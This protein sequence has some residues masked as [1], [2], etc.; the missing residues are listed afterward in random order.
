MSFNLHV[1]LQPND[2]TI[3]LLKIAKAQSE[4]SRKNRESSYCIIR[5]FIQTFGYL[6]F[7]SGF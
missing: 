3:I 5:K 2:R 4:S 7:S 1:F 6:G